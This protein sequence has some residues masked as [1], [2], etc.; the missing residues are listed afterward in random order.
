M[1]VTSVNRNL[2]DGSLTINDGGSLSVTVPCDVGDLRWTETQN[3]QV[4][5]CRGNIDHARPGDEEPVQLSATFKWQQLVAYTDDSSDGPTVYEIVNN[6]GNAF[7]STDDGIYAT[8]WVFTVSDPSTANNDETI[9]F[10]KVVKQTL[11]CSEGEEFNSIA[12]NGISLE[13]RPTI[14]RA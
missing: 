14:A 1:A 3:V 9:T 2:R 8:E 5:M 6:E 12:F 4:Q 7:T 11:E 10:A 13:T